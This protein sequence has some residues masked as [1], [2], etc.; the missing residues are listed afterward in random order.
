M[1]AQVL[2]SALAMVAAT[3]GLLVV[4]VFFEVAIG[5]AHSWWQ[6]IVG[7]AVAGA[8]AAVGIAIIFAA[9]MKTVA[10]TAAGWL[11][12]LTGRVPHDHA[13]GRR[14]ARRGLGDLIL[15]ALAAGLGLRLYHAGA[16]GGELN[17]AIEGLLLTGSGVVFGLLAAV[18]R[19][20][21]ARRGRGD[22]V[23]PKTERGGF[24]RKRDQPRGGD[25]DPEAGADVAV[26]VTAG[27]TAIALSMCA[28]NVI[29]T[30][31][32]RDGRATL[33]YAEWVRGCVDPDGS[34]E[35]CARDV[36]L[37]LVP[38]RTTRLRVEVVSGCEVELTDQEGAAVATLTA[39]ELRA[40]GVDRGDGRDQ[41][42]RL[43]FDPRPG[44]HYRIGLQSGGSACTYSVRYLAEPSGP[45]PGEAGR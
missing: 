26:L 32:L 11:G 38:R 9:M 13:P 19:F 1:I 28:A 5:M 20:Y 10:V 31:R 44:V 29:A 17:W 23:G 15:F 45:A 8:L 16:A 36:E 18:P 7:L 39:A 25:A 33:P 37:T 43:V 40:L 30:A 35:E 24:R 14:N 3:L 41:R 2:S 27:L 21:F 12:M 4:S 6:W 22:P 42:L 34:V